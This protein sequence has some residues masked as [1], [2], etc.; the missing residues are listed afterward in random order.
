MTWTIISLGNR[1]RGDDG[2]G[3]LVL[4]KLRQRQGHAVECFENG[5]DMTQLL[6]DWRERPVCLVDA[7]ALRGRAAGDI[8]HFDG[9][10]EPTLENACTTSSH[11]LNLAEALE[12]G[13]ALGTMPSRLE[14]YAICGEN[15]AIGEP[16]SAGVA[17]AV[18]EVARMIVEHLLTQTG[19]PFCTSNP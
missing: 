16:L 13:R 4:E 5:G 7:V 15:F 18:D 11:G 17:A 8:I 10:A 14:I 12:L 1:F 6:E 19:G 3:P 2:V 9:L